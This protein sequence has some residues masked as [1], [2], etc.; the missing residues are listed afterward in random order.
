MRLCVR[1]APQVDVQKL[2]VRINGSDKPENI[3]WYDY[4]HI[5][6]N[7]RKI[8]CR[9]HGDDIPHIKAKQA[10]KVYMNEPLRGILGVK[11]G[12]VL[13]FDIRK[14]CRLL[15]WWYFIRYHPDDVVRV[16]TYL[17]IIAVLLGIASIIWALLL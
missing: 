3:S 10:S 17:G 1:K 11:V 9:L 4:V 14:A 8:S 6:A 13:E 16:S 15:T 7:S 5:K 12:D 2:R